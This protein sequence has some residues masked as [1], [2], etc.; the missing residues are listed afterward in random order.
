ML[1][2]WSTAV[3]TG[4]GSAR[5]AAEIIKMTEETAEGVSQCPTLRAAA[6]EAGSYRGRLNARSLSHW[7]RRHRGTIAN[8][9]RF[10]GEDDSHGYRWWVEDA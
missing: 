4:K 5:S 10:T 8:G 1:G 7:L 9:Q 3:G 2:A 6:V